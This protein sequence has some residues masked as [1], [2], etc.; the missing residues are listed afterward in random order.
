VV[1]VAA[2]ALL[3]RFSWPVTL[4]TLGIGLIGLHVG[5]ALYDSLLDDVSTEATRGRVSGLGVGVGYVGSF[6]GLGLGLL[7]FEVLG[8]GY[9]GTFG[10]LALGFLL[11]SLPIFVFVRENREIAPGAAPPL[12]KVFAALH[13]SWGRARRVPGMIRFLLGRFL[14]TDA[15]NTLIGGFLAIFVIRELQMT[16]SEVTLVL[17]VAI[18]TAI[19][20][21]LVGGRLVTRFGALPTLR[22][23]LIVWALALGMGVA[24]AIVDSRALIW[25]VAAIGGAALGMTWTSDRVVMLEMSPPQHLGEFYGLYATVGRFATIL[26][27]LTWALVVDVLGWGRRAALV[28]LAGFIIA[29]WHVLGGLRPSA[30]IFP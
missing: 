28:V 7:A 13:E 4:L 23:V 22:T 10:F 21:G 29:G 14:Y 15:I 25:L 24:A 27:P 8:L 12:S 3:T 2:T 16:E 1:A 19:L 5:S 18:A 20:G 6:I 30:R 17:G 9:R 11:F 26:G